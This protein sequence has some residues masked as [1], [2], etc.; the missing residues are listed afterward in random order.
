M[1]VIDDGSYKRLHRLIGK[2]D[3]AMVMMYAPWCHHSA[4]LAKTF[5]DVAKTQEREGEKKVENQRERERKEGE[6]E[7]GGGKGGREGGN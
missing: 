6:G 7:G 5:V 3:V 1:E 2:V 4:K